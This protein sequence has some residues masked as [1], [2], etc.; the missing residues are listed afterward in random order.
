[1]V[2]CCLVCGRIDKKLIIYTIFSSINEIA[3][4]FYRKYLSKPE[5]VNNFVD[6]F[7]KTIGEILGGIL[8]PYIIKYKT[9]KTNNNK[10]RKIK[11][12]IKDYFIL[13]IIN[14]FV[15][16]S[17]V[18][19]IIFCNNSE[20]YKL[21][22]S[23]PKSLEILIFLL[24]T[25]FFMKYT[26][27]NHHYYSMTLFF[28]SNI[29]IDYFVEYF[30]ELEIK[31]FFFYLYYLFYSII[32]CYIK[33]LMDF[34]FKNYWN[35]LFSIGLS[36]IFLFIL[37]FL[38]LLIYQYTKG[39][40]DLIDD[41]KSY[42]INVKN[43]YIIIRS[44][45]EFLFFGFCRPAIRYAFLKEFTPNHLLIGSAFSGFI[46]NYFIY[47]SLHRNF[48]KIF[49]AAIFGLQLASLIIYL[50]I[51]EAK[52]CGLNKNTKRNILL[53]EEIA[54][55]NDDKDNIIDENI[56]L[57][58]G[59]LF[60]EDEEEEENDEKINGNET[61]LDNIQKKEIKEIKEKNI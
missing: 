23:S 38:I 39:K 13:W 15:F 25:L 49:I 56:E 3:S 6:F 7:F 34:K 16:G 48:Y 30:S 51:V 42:Y 9:N 55:L 27:Y 32:I 1:M 59:Y 20:Y 60:K 5:N 52:C 41:I 11:Q 37:Y 45:A 19:L 29:L 4:I 35:I 21:V 44:L 61:E 50:E 2:K 8:I 31:V 43:I 53:R 36:N 46:F 28:I 12:T 22:L 18:L 14:A 26:Y 58:S 10:K 57:S 47:I 54:N 17:N 33:Y 24:I 40:L